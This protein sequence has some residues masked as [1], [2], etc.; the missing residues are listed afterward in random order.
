MLCH[1]LKRASPLFNYGPLLSEP[2]SLRC[3]AAAL[4]FAVAVFIVRAPAVLRTTLCLGA[5]AAGDAALGARLLRFRVCGLSRWFRF[6]VRAL[7]HAHIKA[8]RVPASC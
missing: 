2:G 4:L 3:S 1:R 8:K 6:V 5:F 7:V